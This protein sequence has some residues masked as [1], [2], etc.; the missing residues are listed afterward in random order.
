MSILEINFGEM[1]FRPRI[2]S[3][4]C[5]ILENK[6]PGKCNF[7]QM[8]FGEVKFLEGVFWGGV[9][10]QMAGFGW[11]MFEIKPFVSSVSNF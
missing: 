8:F 11:K 9:G 2:N 7:R 6:F 4:K 5:K 10:S 3:G 1:Y